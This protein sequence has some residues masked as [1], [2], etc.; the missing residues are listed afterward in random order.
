MR[1]FFPAG[2]DRLFALLTAG[3]IA[4]VLGLCAALIFNFNSLVNSFSRRYSSYLLADELRQ[5]SD[6]L[7]RMARTYVLTGD[8]VYRR[9][10]NAFWPSAMEHIRVRCITSGYTGISIFWNRIMHLLTVNRFP[11]R[12]F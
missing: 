7:T 10:M 12:L 11:C 4:A 1:I 8:P 9:P 5:S 3:I 6:D 2:N